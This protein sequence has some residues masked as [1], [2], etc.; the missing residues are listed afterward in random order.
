MTQIELIETNRDALENLYH[1]VGMLTIKDRLDNNET[2]LLAA[3]RAFE[4]ALVN[5]G[6]LEADEEEEAEEEEPEELDYTNDAQH[7]DEWAA[8]QRYDMYRDL[9]LMG[10]EY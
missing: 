9:A 5:M 4:E 8:D 7:W 6:I 10:Y 3:Y 1:A 2:P